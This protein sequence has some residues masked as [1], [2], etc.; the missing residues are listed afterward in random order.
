MMKS[1]KNQIIKFLAATIVFLFMADFSFGQGVDATQLLDKILLNPEYQ[2]E[3]V[4]IRQLRKDKM[5]DKKI[6]DFMNDN[7]AKPR[8]LAAQKRQA[9]GDPLPSNFTQHD[10]LYTSSCNSNDIGVE[11]GTFATWQGQTC[12]WGSLCTPT[13]WTT[14]PLPVAGRVTIVPAPATDPCASNPGFPIPLP[15]PTGGKYSIMLGNNI[16]GGESEKITHQFIV[17]P[18]DTNFIYQYAV[19]FQDPGIFLP[20]NPFSIL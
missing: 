20:I 2:K 8:R 1:S 3:S 9:S 16:T 4:V 13:S 10:L 17:Q 12:V 14:V 7:Y 5:D 11:L 15:S 18:T 6:L 19:V